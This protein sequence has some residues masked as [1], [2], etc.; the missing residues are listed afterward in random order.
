MWERA[1]FFDSVLVLIPHMQ[2]D[3]KWDEDGKVLKSLV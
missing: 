3:D 1:E 2:C